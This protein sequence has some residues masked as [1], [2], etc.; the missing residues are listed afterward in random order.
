MTKR[1]ATSHRQLELSLLSDLNSRTA[2]PR[3]SV[4]A[5]AREGA[6]SVAGASARDLSV[7]RQ[8]SSAYFDSLPDGLGPRV[9]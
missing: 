7:Y 3:P 6:T 9:K 4:A 1:Q 5:A 2:A 8:I